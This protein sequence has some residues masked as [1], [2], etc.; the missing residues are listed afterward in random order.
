MFNSNVLTLTLLS[1]IPF[2]SQQ[3][4]ADNIEKPSV[5]KNIIMVIADGMGPAYTSAYRYFN[6]DPNTIIVEETVFDKHLKGLSSTYPAAISGY[7]T[8]S[9]AAATALATGFKTYNNA[10]SVDVNKKPLLTV[11]ELAKQQGKKTGVVVTSRINHATPAAYLTHNEHRDNYNEIAD[12]YIDQGIKADVYFGGGRKSFIRSDRNLVKEFQQNGFQYIEQYEQLN[13][14]DIT[15]PV[16]GLFADY[17][18]PWAI[19]DNNKH[20]LT[21]MVNAAMKHLALPENNDNGFFMLIEGSLIDWAG[22]DNDIV[23]SLYEM[24][25]LANTIHYLE[26]FVAENPDTLVIVTA[27]HSTGGLTLAVKEEYI[28]D[29]TVIRTMTQSPNA[30]AIKIVDHHKSANTLPTVSKI[31]QWLNFSLSSDEY[32]QLT[33][34]QADYKVARAAYELLSAAE[35]QH[36]ADEYKTPTFVGFY[37]KVLMSIIDTRSNT[38]WTTSGHTAIDVP[39]FAFGKQSEFFNGQLDN[40]DIAKKI[41]SLLGK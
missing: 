3:A 20:R 16:M 8:D 23:N 31:S 4:V 12:S 25:D 30:I 19:D 14:L 33:Q 39:V 35:K 9:A 41:F 37:Q 21:P 11:L 18:L 22:H 38:G 15:N 40:T 36:L 7:V 6:D 27:D 26:N 32:N 17:S 24:D 2:I 34:V 13:S 10:I 5:P 1:I 29:P 28:W